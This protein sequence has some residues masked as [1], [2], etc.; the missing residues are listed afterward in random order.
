M[1]MPGGAALPGQVRNPF[2]KSLQ[3]QE[4]QLAQV[5]GALEPAKSRRCSA[6]MRKT[7]AP[8]RGHCFTR[9]EPPAQTSQH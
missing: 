4:A 6:S 7:S 8:I 2:R 1:Q 5:P 9:D 3:H